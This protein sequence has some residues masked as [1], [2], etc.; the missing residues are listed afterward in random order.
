[1]QVRW[2]NGYDIRYKSI[3]IYSRVILAGWHVGNSDTLPVKY[4]SGGK[5]ADYDCSIQ[6]IGGLNNACH[7][8]PTGN[9][10]RD[11]GNRCGETGRLPLHENLTLQPQDGDWLRMV[12][13]S[14]RNEN[15]S[16]LSGIYFESYMFQKNA[17]TLIHVSE[18]LVCQYV[19]T[20]PAKVRALVVRKSLTDYQMV[21]TL[22][23]ASLR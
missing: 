9:W 13:I 8:D 6:D 10:T 12:R 2:I 5:Y 14:D 15:V 18:G 20:I 22:Y 7:T 4:A 16:S 11:I 1:M 21:I 17:R 3:P 19:I 23:L